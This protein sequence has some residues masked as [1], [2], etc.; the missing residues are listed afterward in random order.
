MRRFLIILGIAALGCQ[1]TGQYPSPVA[2][3]SVTPVA[4]QGQFPSP[5][6]S[7]TVTPVPTQASP[8]PAR[9]NPFGL[10]LGAP[11]LTIEQRIT[12]VQQM[13]APYFRPNAG[14]VQSWNGVCAECD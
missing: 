5:V 14:F 2:P 8:M 7:D 4:T 10:M 12:L 13:G 9:D 3:A 11:D 1:I 6:A